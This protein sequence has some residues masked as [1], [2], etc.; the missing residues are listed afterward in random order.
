MNLTYKQLLLLITP[1]LL[2]I[3][4]GFGLSLSEMTNPERVLG[5]LDV[6]GTWDPTLLLVMIGALIISIPSFQLLRKIEQPVLEKKFFMPTLKDIDLKLI[7]GACLFGIGWGL[8]GLCPGP[9]VVV[10]ATLDASAVIF[11]FSM[12]AGMIIHKILY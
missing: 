6:T 7:S 10:L 8:A 1:G 11:M 5:F 4:F 12:L 2:G 3:L 9:A